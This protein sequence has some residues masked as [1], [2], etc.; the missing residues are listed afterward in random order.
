[1]F[2]P[3]IYTII[4]IAD[5]AYGVRDFEI[6]GIVVNVKVHEIDDICWCRAMLMKMLHPNWIDL[7]PGVIVEQ[8]PGRLQMFFVIFRS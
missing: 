1:M 6:A 4:E 5:K 3:G 8:L 7:F 2:I